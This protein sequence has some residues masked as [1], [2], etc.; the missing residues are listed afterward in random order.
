MEAARAYSYPTKVK[1]MPSAIRELLLTDGSFIPFL[2]ASRTM[3][4]DHLKSF[5]SISLKGSAILGVQ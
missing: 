1:Q 2:I 5:D 3:R 4:F